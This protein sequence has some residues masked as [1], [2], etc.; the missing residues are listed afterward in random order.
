MSNTASVQHRTLRLLAIAQIFSGIGVGAVVSTGSL[1]AVQLSGSEAWAGSVTTTM[2][3]G[4]AFASA[5]LL[6][7]AVVHGRRRSLA[8]GLLLGA[9]G[10]GTVVLAAVTNFFPL[11][12]LAGL[13]VGFGNAVNLQARFAATDLSQPDQPQPRFIAH[14]VDEYDWLGG[15]PKPHCYRRAGR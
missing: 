8:T 5:L 7:I 4:A 14:H 9:I 10:A 11:L 13:L 1:L 12:L 3:L 6:R 2:T 15:W